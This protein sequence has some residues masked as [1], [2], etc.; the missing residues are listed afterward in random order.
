MMK[1]KRGVMSEFPTVWRGRMKNTRGRAECHK[2]L[3]SGV[4]RTRCGSFLNVVEY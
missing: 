2:G 4:E 3:C 1:L